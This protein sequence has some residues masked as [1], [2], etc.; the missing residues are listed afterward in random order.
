[1]APD[2]V[3]AVIGLLSAAGE[4][5]SQIGQIQTRQDTQPATLV[6]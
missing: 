6:Q 5:V 1:V 3:Q 2:Q 4:Q